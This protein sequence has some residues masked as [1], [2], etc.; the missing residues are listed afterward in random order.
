MASIA[1]A[2][3]AAFT[4]AGWGLGWE[5]TQK[6]DTQNLNGAAPPQISYMLPLE[7]LTEA[8]GQKKIEMVRR[9]SR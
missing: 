6:P 8:V 2:I 3:Q 5:G 7:D 1:T 9:P 4:L